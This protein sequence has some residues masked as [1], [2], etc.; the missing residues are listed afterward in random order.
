MAGTAFVDQLKAKFGA[1]IS[2]SNFE[3]I[4]P[5]IEVTP[6]GLLEVCR[7]LRDEPTLAFDYLN[8][9]SGVDYLHTDAGGE[10]YAFNGTFH[11][12]RENEFAIQ[13]FEF[14]GYPDVVAVES[15]AF[16][17]LGDGRSRL[18]IHSTYPSLEARDGMVASN[19][20]VGVREGY[21]RLEGLLA[22]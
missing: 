1:K 16:D 5:W 13:T 22:A 20:E 18:R 17:D 7:Y 6:G 9:I 14:E 19:M 21:E 15:L 3:N 10:T 4:D 8:C 11:N 2:G 12:V